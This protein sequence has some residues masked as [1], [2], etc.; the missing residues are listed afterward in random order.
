MSVSDKILLRYQNSDK[1]LL[2]KQNSK[3][4]FDLETRG[5]VDNDVCIKQ[6]SYRISQFGQNSAG[7]A[8]FQAEFWLQSNKEV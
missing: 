2:R 8:K 6:N 5:D 1:I 4:N 3:Q 7:K